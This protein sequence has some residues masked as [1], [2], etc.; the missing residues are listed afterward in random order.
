MVLRLSPY[1]QRGP[2]MELPSSP[3][4]PG[5]TTLGVPSS[6]LT[7]TSVIPVWIE[8]KPARTPDVHPARTTLERRPT[9]KRKDRME[10]G[11]EAGYRPHPTRS[12]HTIAA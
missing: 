2:E 10:I 5:I 4:S 7:W 1:C 8:S 3:V 12:S 6:S 11:M 9:T